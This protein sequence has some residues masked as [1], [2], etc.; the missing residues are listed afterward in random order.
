MQDFDTTS[1]QSLIDRYYEE[2]KAQRL[3]E[4]T[5]AAFTIRMDAN[6]LAMLNV[7]ARRFRKNREEVAQEILSN[8]LIDLFAR[9]DGGERKLMARDADDAARSIADE[10]AEENG[11]MSID[12][13]AGVWANHDRQITKQERKK[14]KQAEKSDVPETSSSQA[15]E[16]EYDSQEADV[17][18]EAAIEEEMLAEESLE[19]EEEN[20][21]ATAAQP[22]SV[23]AS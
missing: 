10:I 11:V 4:Q 20:D 21:T 16:D 13:K 7:I 19:S 22:M 1:T 18:A 15:A 12:V 3:R 9:I 6:D 17:A 8:A 5:L 14:A 2:E 23:F